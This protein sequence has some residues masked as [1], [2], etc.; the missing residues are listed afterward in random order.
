MNR[1]IKLALITSLIYFIFYNL[2]N[3]TL[4]GEFKWE[5]SVISSII[6]FVVYYLLLKYIRKKEL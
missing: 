4:Y 5:I 6:F 3:Y 1:E 2:V